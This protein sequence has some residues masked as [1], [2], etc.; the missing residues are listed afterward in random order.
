M[1]G[2]SM[3]E[4][5]QVYPPPPPFAST[6][7]LACTRESYSGNIALGSA[8][9]TVWYV[10]D[11]Y[12]F[13]PI[14]CEEKS[15]NFIQ[16]F[17]NL[18]SVMIMCLSCSKLSFKSLTAALYKDLISMVVAVLRNNFATVENFVFKIVFQ[19]ITIISINWNY[20]Q[21]QLPLKLLKY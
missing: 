3:V 10:P 20:S 7:M 13:S 8:R 1:W 6:C 15:S 16:I 11:Q 12:L 9:L 14:I 19:I 4:P 5:C 2:T 18:C 21:K 17:M